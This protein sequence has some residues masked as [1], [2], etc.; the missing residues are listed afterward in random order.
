MTLECIKVDLTDFRLP[1]TED[2]HEKRGDTFSLGYKTEV[3]S[4]AVRRVQGRQRRRRRTL[5]CLS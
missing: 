3:L 2:H 4:R 5:S 1:Q